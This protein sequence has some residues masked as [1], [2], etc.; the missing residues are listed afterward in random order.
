M[1]IGLYRDGELYKTY[2]DVVEIESDKD[3]YNQELIRFWR[4]GSHNEFIVYLGVRV[5]E[6]QIK[7]MEV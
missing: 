7:V 2:D 3:L 5:S 4:K 1:R 6:W